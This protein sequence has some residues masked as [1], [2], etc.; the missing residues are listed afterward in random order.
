MTAYVRGGAGGS[1][2]LSAEGKKGRPERQRHLP[3]PLLPAVA[4]SSN[5]VIP[6]IHCSSNAR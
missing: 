4:A 5:P 1:V 2:T 3:S 6:L